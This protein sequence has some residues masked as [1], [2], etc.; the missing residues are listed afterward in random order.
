MEISFSADKIW[1]WNGQTRSGS[2]SSSIE[3]LDLASKAIAF[4]G[5]EYILIYIYIYL[6]TLFYLILFHQLRYSA[7]HGN[8]QQVISTVGHS[9]F[10]CGIVIAD[11]MDLKASKRSESADHWLMDANETKVVPKNADGTPNPNLATHQILFDGSLVLRKARRLPR[12]WLR[13]A[14][15]CLNHFECSPCSPRS[16]P[17]EDEH[18]AETAVAVQKAKKCILQGAFLV[19]Q[20]RSAMDCQGMSAVSGVS[21]W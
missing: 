6:Y 11:N 8:F 13:D 12:F 16:P 9:R 2:P 21:V 1:C 7:A 15:R 3:R 18:G 20:V 17:K 5:V 4:R 19:R 10:C 14:M